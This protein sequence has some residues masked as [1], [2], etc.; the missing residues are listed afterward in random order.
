MKIELD[1]QLADQLIAAIL[2][3]TH[4]TLMD[5]I[6]NSASK[7]ENGDQYLVDLED[8]HRV[9]FAVKELYRYYKGVDL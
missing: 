3:D 2:V 1:S 6:K 7:L 8:H 5:D 4:D 9:L